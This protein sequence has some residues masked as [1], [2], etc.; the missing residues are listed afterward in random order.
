MDPST[1]QRLKP[2][3]VSNGLRGAESAALPRESRFAANA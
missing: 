3:L 1:C 2:V